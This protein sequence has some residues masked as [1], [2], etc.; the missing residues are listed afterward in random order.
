MMLVIIWAAILAPT[1]VRVCRLW[2]EEG[3]TS[4]GSGRTPAAQ[5]ELPDCRRG[6]GAGN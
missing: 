2:V 3:F 6:F 1:R 5:P 4:D